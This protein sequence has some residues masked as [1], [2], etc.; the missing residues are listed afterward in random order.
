MGRVISLVLIGW[1]VVAGIQRRRE[2]GVLEDERDHAIRSSACSAAH[3]V[4][5]LA[6]IAVILLLGFL[7]HAQAAEATPLLIA[8]G[9]IG[10][11]IL[12]SLV[13]HATSLVLYRRDRA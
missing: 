13:E 7:P 8:H 12:S 6:L 1:L 3:S 10:T 5:V 2:P 9:L 4:L 11:L